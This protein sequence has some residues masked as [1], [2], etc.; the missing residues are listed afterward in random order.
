M[1]WVFPT[2]LRE[3]VPHDSAH[4]STALAHDIHEQILVHKR[5]LFLVGHTPGSGFIADDEVRSAFLPPLSDGAVLRREDIAMNGYTPIFMT[6]APEDL[7]VIESN[8][9]RELKRKKRNTRARRGVVLPDREPLKTQRTLINP[10]GPNGLA[11]PIIAETVS[12]PVVSSRRAAAIAA[13]ANINLLAQDLPLPQ[14]PTPPPQPTIVRSK[15]GR[16]A[17]DPSRE[18]SVVH[19]GEL[20]PSVIG[21]R[22]FR[23]DSVADTVGMGSPMP[24]NK[25]RNGRIIESPDGDGN[26]VDISAPVKAEHES[27]GPWRCTNCGVPEHLSGGPRRDPGGNRTLCGTCAR[28]QA[29]TNKK[30]PVEY[31]EDEEYHRQRI[32]LARKRNGAA[33][34]GHF[35]GSEMGDD[36]MSPST[37]TTP[38]PSAMPLL[39]PQHNRTPQPPP[40]SL[41]AN[42]QP[43]QQPHPAHP[44][45]P[46]MQ[47]QPQTT[48]P[49]RSLLKDNATDTSDSDS[50]D[51]DDDDDFVPA[52]QNQTRAVPTPGR[53]VSASGAAASPVAST[54]S[55]KTRE[56]PP[57]WTSRVIAETQGRYPQ[58][59]FAVVPKAKTDGV[60][61]PTEWRL[62]CLD[63]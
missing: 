9:D 53:T 44:T 20:T 15:R 52:A 13:Q 48:L 61:A 12:A 38:L 42:V 3:Y 56:E 49:T 35:T 23:E 27:T 16:A 36:D 28:H 40:R 18:T 22:G 5:S 7:A 19:P 8:R 1:S 25:R 29:R 57:A 4:G 58:D 46:S 59:R 45:Q 30:R 33:A 51:S 2:S 55:A 31:T 47:Y 34:A 21:K 39:S 26:D 24:A 63:W 43:M 10:I 32:E 17:R 54:P 41:S 62:K 11:L 37:M 50:S 60:E 14:P 6:H